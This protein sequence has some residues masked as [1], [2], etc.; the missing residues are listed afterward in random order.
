[1]TLRASRLAV[2]TA[3][4]IGV[5]ILYACWQQGASSLAEEIF[6]S[7]GV[8]PGEMVQSASQT[9][10]VSCAKVSTRQKLYTRSSFEF[11]PAFSGQL[12]PF[13]LATRLR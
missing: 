3:P 6:G 4:Q 13:P 11:I 7:D 2:L 9:S 5:T 8:L 1:M 10:L 12:V